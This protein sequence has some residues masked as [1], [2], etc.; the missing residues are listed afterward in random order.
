M[1]GR[2]S[3]SLASFAFVCDHFHKTFRS[4]ARANHCFFWCCENKDVV[5]RG[6][7]RFGVLKIVWCSQMK[8]GE[9]KMVC[10]V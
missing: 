10:K 2:C 6:G 5:H 3:Q 7:K 8:K 1:D 9:R 4:I